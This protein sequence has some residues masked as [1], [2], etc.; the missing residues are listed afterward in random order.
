MRRMPIPIKNAVEFV[1]PD[2][3][4]F[5]SQNARTIAAKESLDSGRAVYLRLSACGQYFI[6]AES[7][8][9]D[10]DPTVTPIGREKAA[11]LFNRFP[12]RCPAALAFPR[13]TRR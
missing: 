9:D 7:I 2:G 5:R 12:L 6:Q 3:T 13:R 10:D 11:S 4:I 1:R 8:F